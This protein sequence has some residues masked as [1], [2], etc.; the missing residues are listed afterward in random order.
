MDSALK[1]KIFESMEYD[2]LNRYVYGVKGQIHIYDKKKLLFQLVI[3][4]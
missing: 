3:L 4:I 2:S 1:K